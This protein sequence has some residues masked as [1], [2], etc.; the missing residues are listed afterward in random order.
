MQ[1]ATGRQHGLG[2]Q[3]D[4]RDGRRKQAHAIIGRARRSARG[5]RRCDPEARARCT[6]IYAAARYPEA[7]T[8]S[9]P[10]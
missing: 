5:E 9:D 1:V 2:E 7:G 3:L 8:L 6:R 10:R 4:A